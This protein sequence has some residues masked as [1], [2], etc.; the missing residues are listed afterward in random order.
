MENLTFFK[1]N[2]RNKNVFDIFYK[3]N[4]KN[5][6]RVEKINK[7]DPNKQNELGFVKEIPKTNQFENIPKI[8][9]DE[10]KKVDCKINNYTNNEDVLDKMKLESC[11]ESI[12]NNIDTISKL[13]V[14]L[15]SVNLDK[16]I[17]L[18]IEKN[19]LIVPDKKDIK[20]SNIIKENKRKN[21]DLNKINIFK[22]FK[23]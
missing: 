3:Q 1:Q 6:N 21:S 5:L 20:E 14:N 17:P 4:F 11:K 12:E 22:R 2:K 8:E 19:D 16:K 23:I 18:K 7:Y 15:E 13:D 10:I 9:L